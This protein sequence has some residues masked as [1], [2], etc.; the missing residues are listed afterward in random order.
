MKPNIKIIFPEYDGDRKI[1]I[2]SVKISKNHRR[3][4]LT[5]SEDL[6]PE[7]LEK[8]EEQIREKYHLTSVHIHQKKMMIKKNP[9][10]LI[11]SCLL[12]SQM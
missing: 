3:M 7:V 10:H 6:D 8:F 1:E 12:Q 5:L 9:S 4:E 11:F 2:D